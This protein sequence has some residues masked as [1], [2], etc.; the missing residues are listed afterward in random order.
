VRNK[1]NAFAASA[2]LSRGNGV[3]FESILRAADRSNGFHTA[4]TRSGYWR[5]MVKFWE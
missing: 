3:L 1:R 4:K 5:A 2:N